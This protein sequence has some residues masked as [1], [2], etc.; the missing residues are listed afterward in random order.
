MLFCNRKIIFDHFCYRYCSACMFQNTSFV[1]INTKNCSKIWLCLRNRGTETSGSRDVTAL[2]CSE[3]LRSKVGGASKPS[4]CY[5][6]WD[7]LTIACLVGL[8]FLFLIAVSL[9][10]GRR[11]NEEYCFIL[12]LIGLHLGRYPSEA[13]CSKME[14]TSSNDSK[15][16]LFLISKSFG[17]FKNFKDSLEILGGQSS[18][19]LSFHQ[20]L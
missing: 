6:G 9:C 16:L 11:S 17:C 2:R 8:L 14:L 15:S 3:P 10:T 20:F 12:L 7:R 13:V 4:P 1:F 19:I 18:K 5:A